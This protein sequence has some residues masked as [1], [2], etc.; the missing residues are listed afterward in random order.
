MRVLM[1]SLGMRLDAEFRLYHEVEDC[2]AIG[3][4]DRVDPYSRTFMIDGERFRIDDII[5]ATIVGSRM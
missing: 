1:E 3:V 5:G 4:V 2:A